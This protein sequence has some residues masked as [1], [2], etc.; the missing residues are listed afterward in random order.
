MSAHQ[1]DKLKQME[2]RIRVLEQWTGVPMHIE[3][4][5]EEVRANLDYPHG[6]DQDM[7]PE[8]EHGRGAA[9]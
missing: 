3:V 8:T 5:E 9:A 4:S 6:Y 1:T 2:D 7:R